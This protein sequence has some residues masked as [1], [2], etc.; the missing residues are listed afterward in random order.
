M[1]LLVGASESYLFDTYQRMFDFFILT[2]VVDEFRVDFSYASTVNETTSKK[3]QRCLVTTTTP[4]LA[5][6]QQTIS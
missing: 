3:A 1:S 4:T 5:R 2:Q 6:Y